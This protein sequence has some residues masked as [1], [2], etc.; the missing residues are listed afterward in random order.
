MFREKTVKVS[1]N[2]KKAG[3]SC[4]G[5]KLNNKLIFILERSAD[6]KRALFE[7]SNAIF[8]NLEKLVFLTR[9]QNIPKNVFS[10]GDLGR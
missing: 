5:V 10:A 4:R 1:R 6:P 7:N 3:I 8:K 2:K 9:F